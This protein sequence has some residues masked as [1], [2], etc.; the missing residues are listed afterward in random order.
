MAGERREPKWLA[1]LGAAFAP[2]AHRV[3]IVCR[4]LQTMDGQSERG[5]N[6]IA[7]I[8]GSGRG[9]RNRLDELGAHSRTSK[10]ALANVSDH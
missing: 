8:I 7:I 4:P 9:W 5:T 6:S 1:E 3:E 10:H 2:L